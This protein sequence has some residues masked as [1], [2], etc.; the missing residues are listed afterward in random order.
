MSA[1]RRVANVA[2]MAAMAWAL[3]KNWPAKRD[4]AGRHPGGRAD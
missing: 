3:A 4:K 2:W 1:T